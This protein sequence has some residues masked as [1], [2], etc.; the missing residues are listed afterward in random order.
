MIAIIWAL[1]IRFSPFNSFHIQ[2]VMG[3]SLCAIF[4][5]VLFW[6]KF[7][8][9]IA[10]GYLYFSL[11]CIIKAGL[12]LTFW[13]HF[14]L[15]EVVGFESLVA[16]AGLYL[17]LI[18]LIFYFSKDHLEIIKRILL[19]FAFVDIFI[20]GIRYSICLYSGTCYDS[21]AYFLLNNP[22][23]DI[24]FLSCVLPLLLNFK[25]ESHES[26]YVLYAGVFTVMGIILLGF[27]TKT[28]SGIAGVGCAL[29]AYFWAKG[30]FKKKY[31]LI[32]LGLIAGASVAGYLMQGDLL[33]NTSGRGR[34][35]QIA[36][37][38]WNLKVNKLFGAG[39]GTFQMYGQGLQIN[40]SIKQ[41][42]ISNNLL[43]IDLGTDA[44]NKAMQASE[45]LRACLD[46]TTI[47]GFVWLHNDWL[48]VLFEGGIIG[49]VISAT[50]FAVAIYKA[51]QFPAVFAS[52]LTYGVL[53]F[54]QMPTKHFV[55]TCLGAYLITFSLCSPEKQA[56]YSSRQE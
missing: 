54:I 9:L 5:S 46:K 56:S 40:D 34:V 21:G 37:E 18:T 33:L 2:N 36:M 24:A 27:L 12:P 52:L 55:Y 3:L 50:V 26:R 8:P 22:A 48:Q 41:C 7:H 13:D 4:L 23:L 15:S 42:L 19:T 47:S 10:I 38:F 1:V 6:R 17:T 30:N 44:F 16:Q 29:G 45:P 14:E 51:R 53:A 20:M 32:T 25:I 28:S 49:L 43:G 31:L 35:W 39:I 11:S